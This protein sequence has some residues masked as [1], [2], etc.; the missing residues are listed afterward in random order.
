METKINI[1][2]A[3]CFALFVIGLLSVGAD[4][5]SAFAAALLFAPLLV[6]FFTG[7]AIL[8]ASVLCLFKRTSPPAEPIAWEERM[9]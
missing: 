7:P 9:D 2:V 8:F 1:S 6:A 5:L 3:I 4:L